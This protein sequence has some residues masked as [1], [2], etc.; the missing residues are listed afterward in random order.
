MRHLVLLA[1]L[2]ASAAQSQTERVRTQAE[3]MPALI[4][5]A[6]TALAAIQRGL[7]YPDSLLDAG[8]DGTVIVQLTVDADGG[9]RDSVVARGLH[10]LLDAEALRAVAGL[11]F[12]PAQ[13][14]GQPVAVRTIVPIRFD[15]ELA[16][17]LRDAPHARR[18][19]E[20]PDV[21]ARLLPDAPT[22]MRALQQQLV[23]PLSAGR[24]GADGRVLIQFT[25]S[26]EGQAEEPV[27]LRS[28]GAAV[29]SVAVRALGVLT[30]APARKDGQPIASVLT[31]PLTFQAPA[32]DA[33]RQ[34]TQ[35]RFQITEV[36][37]QLLPSFQEAIPQMQ[38]DLR[39][40]PQACAEG[41]EGR[42]IVQFIVDEEGRVT[43][44]FVREGL[45]YGADEEALRLVRTLRFSP[46]TTDGK[47]VPVQMTLPVL[48]RLP[49]R[50]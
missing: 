44:P 15:A 8:T 17:G 38:R 26:S 12:V 32:T 35:A 46:G 47:A 27:V 34:H 7:V 42:V 23:L 43:Q 5:D 33:Q 19:F 29:D 48:F 11:R 1:L 37:P 41:I 3:Q 45:G 24:V 36:T 2:A 9:V 18:A 39:Y 22:A 21:A 13:H 50:C 28:G 25:V 30:F 10:P 6:R 40:P 31:W 16:R 20:L 49:N 4:P 14:Q